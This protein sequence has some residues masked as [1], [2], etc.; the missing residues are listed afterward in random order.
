M[1]DPNLIKDNPNAVKEAALAKGVHLDIEKIN[2]MTWKAKELQTKVE[3]LRAKRNLLNEKLSKDRDESSLKEAG[4]LKAELDRLEKELKEDA[5]KIKEEYYK[6]P[7]LPAKDV[8]IGA[9]E[10]A[11]EVIKTFGEPT[12]FDF[13]PKDHLQIGEKLNLIDTERAAKISGARFAYL[14]NE[15]VL[16]EFALVQLAMKVL[17]EAGFTPVVPPVLVRPEIAQGLGYWEGLGKN[18]YYTIDDPDEGGYYLVGTAEHSL[19]PMH[20]D[21]IFDQAEMPKR[22]VGFS[23]SFRREAGSYGKDTRGIIRVH[24]FDKVEMV[25]FVTAEDDD[26]EHEFLLSLEEKLFQLLKIPYQV[27]KMGS[28]DLGFPIARKYDIEAWIPS[29]NKY[30]EVT[31]ASTAT[32]F[33]ARRLNIRY[34]DQDSTKYVHILNGTAFAIGRTIVAILENFQNAD[35]SVTVPEALVVYVGKEKIG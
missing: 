10:S 35:G 18:D 30:R 29:Q 28:G 23:T 33:Q 31:S 27:I 17:M 8:K 24:Q 21:E 14:K 9:G 12:K 22:Y 34:R 6:I 25:S 15:G 20:K 4:E 26:K 11:N 16:L 32:D 3:S 13:D 19:V 1:I 5:P 7:N 2:Q